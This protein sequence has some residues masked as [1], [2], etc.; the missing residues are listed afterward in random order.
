MTS[1]K[2]LNKIIAYELSM[3]IVP[4]SSSE[5]KSLALISGQSSKNKMRKKNQT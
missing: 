1:S 4:S 2:V 3:G 5:V